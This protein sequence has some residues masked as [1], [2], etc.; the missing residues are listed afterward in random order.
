MVSSIKMALRTLFLNCGPVGRAKEIGE[1]EGKIELWRLGETGGSGGP[2]VV[3][4]R[5]LYFG[6]DTRHGSKV[7]KLAH[8]SHGFELGQTAETWI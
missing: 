8:G 7:V 5:Y 1:K 3:H 4:C 2:A 6:L